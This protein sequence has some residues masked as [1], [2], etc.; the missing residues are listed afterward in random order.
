M[1]LWL[2]RICAQPP[3]GFVLAPSCTDCTWRAE[4]DPSLQLRLCVPLSCA[5]GTLDCNTSAS[6]SK[7]HVLS[8]YKSSQQQTPPIPVLSSYFLRDSFHRI[9]ARIRY[10]QQPGADLQ[11]LAEIWLTSAE[12]WW[13]SCKSAS[14][15]T[16]QSHPRNEI[17]SSIWHWY[18]ASTLGRDR[19][20]SATSISGPSDAS[21]KTDSASFA[22]CSICLAAVKAGSA[23]SLSTRFFAR[24]KHSESLSH[25]ENIWLRADLKHATFAENASTTTFTTAS[26]GC[27]NQGTSSKSIKH[28]FCGAEVFCRCCLTFVFCRQ[29]HTLAAL[30]I[31]HVANEDFL[32]W[33]RRAQKP[34][35]L[36]A[37]HFLP[38]Y[39]RL[40]STLHAVQRPLL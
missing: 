14:F 3:L 18:S 1:K 34:Q 10:K 32:P 12:H 7:H 40:S 39:R 28:V 26:P 25:S 23:H 6:L 38:L 4:P 17:L 15:T 35:E 37:Q 11:N 30:Q 8:L 31:S 22:L 36:L 5:L 24:Q 29:Q 16:C 19:G 20:W 21:I 33:E 27:L 9:C 13:F 2:F